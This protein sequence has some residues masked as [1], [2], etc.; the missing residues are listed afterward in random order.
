M[1]RGKLAEMEQRIRSTAFRPGGLV[2]QHFRVVN[3]LGEGACGLVFLA[4]DEF[5]Q[6]QVAV[7]VVAPDDPKLRPFLEQRFRDEAS[8]MA[9]VVHPNVVQVYSVGQQDGLPFMVTEY[10]DGPT[11]RLVMAREGALPPIR[12]ISLIEQAAA[13]LD[14]LHKQG[15]AHRDVK[16]ANLLLGDGDRVRIIDLGL[17]RRYQREPHDLM[18]TPDYIAPEILIQQEVHPE[19]RHLCDVYALGVCAYE[20]LTAQCPYNGSTLKELVENKVTLAP[21]APSCFRPQIPAAM[22]EA[23]LRALARSPAE[24]FE[25]CSAFADSLANALHQTWG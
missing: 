5:L 24:R 7:K 20:L 6:R 3:L 1:R 9:Q 2:G 16:P 17:S 21:L 23:V 25:S 18:G 15:I 8:A 11:L 12:V 13:G 19:Q 22:D 4:N 10:V 14:V